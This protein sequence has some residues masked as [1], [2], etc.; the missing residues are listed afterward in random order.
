MNEE[1][2]TPID[3]A[4]TPCDSSQ[5]HAYGYDAATGTLALQFKR[6]DAEGNRV[7]GSVYQ[8]DNVPAEI[9]AEF[10]A[11]ESKG[12]YFGSHIKTTG[13]AFRRLEQPPKEDEAAVEASGE[14]A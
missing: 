11:A 8:Y 9:Y 13:F 1:T 3:I 5:I 2:K 6:K 7:G 10:C 4:M 12:A 14:V